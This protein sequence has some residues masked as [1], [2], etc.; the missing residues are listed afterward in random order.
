MRCVYVYVEAQHFNI[1]VYWN[2]SKCASLL[3]SLT[4]RKANTLMNLE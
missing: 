3:F 1:R 2:S 4:I